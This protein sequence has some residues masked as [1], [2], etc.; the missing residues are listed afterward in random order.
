MAGGITAVATALGMAGI[1]AVA[2]TIATAAEAMAEDIMA[3]GTA[4]G[5][6]GMSV[7]IAADI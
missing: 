1:I 7:A 5:V 6:V 4:A 3:V 2:M